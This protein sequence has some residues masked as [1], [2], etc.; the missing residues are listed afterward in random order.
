[1]SIR[2]I[3]PRGQHRA[4]YEIKSDRIEVLR[5]VHLAS[6]DSAEQELLED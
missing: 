4:I 6:R 1:M 3:F 2:R 5:I